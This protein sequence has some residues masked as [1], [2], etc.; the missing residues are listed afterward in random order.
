MTRLWIVSLFSIF[1]GFSSA[2]TFAAGEVKTLMVPKCDESPVVDGQ[3]DAVWSEIPA[4]TDFCYPWRPDFPEP[5]SLKL[6]HDAKNLYLFWEVTDS[7]PVFL[8][9]RDEMDIADEDRVEV[10]FEDQPSMKN[11]YSIETSPTGLALDYQCVYHR[12]FDFSWSFPGLVLAGERRETG[13][14][15]EAA[16]PLEELR[17]LGLLKE[18]G[19]I[20]AGFYRADFERAAD[21]KVIQKWIS[22][23][24]PIKP[25]EDF[26][27]PETLGLLKLE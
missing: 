18:D 19:T 9:Q 13:Y 14:T 17:K 6:C 24:N 15:V 5:T 2:I 27:I 22:W 8:K 7:T 1:L 20:R 23:I 25:K 26:H 21:G 4:T 12:H 10:Y 3:A 11:Y 16:F